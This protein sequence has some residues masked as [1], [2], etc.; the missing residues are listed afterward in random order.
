[1]VDS[2]PD[3]EE[4]KKSFVERKL[5]DLEKL[6]LLQRV[7]RLEKINLFYEEYIVNTSILDSIKKTKTEPNQ[8]QQQ[9]LPD[10]DDKY[11]G[12]ITTNQ[13]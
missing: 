10:K 9:G 5:E 4:H 13:D 7:K 11:I 3:I 12:T 1:M 6:E 2:Q 8:Q